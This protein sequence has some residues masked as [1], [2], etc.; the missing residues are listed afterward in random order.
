L[1]D[2]ARA[3]AELG[4]QRAEQEQMAARVQAASPQQERQ[5]AAS[6]QLEAP[7]DAAAL[8]AQP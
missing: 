8:A 4:P 2:A 7:P 3:Q 1:P 6:A 5:R